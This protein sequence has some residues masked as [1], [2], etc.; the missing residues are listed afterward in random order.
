MYAPQGL[1]AVFSS[2]LASSVIIMAARPSLLP[3]CIV[4]VL[5][6]C[7]HIPELL[8]YALLF[9]RCLL[10][11]VVA[12]ENSFPCFAL[13]GQKQGKT[14]LFMVADLRKMQENQWVSEIR[15]EKFRFAYLRRSSLIKHTL[16]TTIIIA[17]ASEATNCPIAAAGIGCNGHG[18]MKLARQALNIQTTVR[19]K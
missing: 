1:P 4:P 12:T 16:T 2:A 19:K 7:L 13:Q 14:E 6:F 5:G 15:I 8:S 10:D 3:P 18:S 17:N 9:R 11:K